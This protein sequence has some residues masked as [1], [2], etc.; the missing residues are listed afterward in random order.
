ME[1]VDIPEHHATSG[2]A[3]GDDDF[4]DLQAAFSDTPLGGSCHFDGLTSADWSVQ[5]ELRVGESSGVVTSADSPGIFVAGDSS[6]G[7]SGDLESEPDFVMVDWPNVSFG[8]DNT[9]ALDDP[10][11]EPTMTQSQFQQGFSRSLLT[12]C[13]AVSNIVMPWEQGVFRELFSDDPYGSVVPQMPLDNLVGPLQPGMEPQHVGEVVASATVFEQDGPVYMDVI[14]SKDDVDFPSR[15]ELLR[16]RALAKLLVV[17]EYSLE[18]SST[19]RHIASI[20]DGNPSASESFHILDAVV[21][22]RSPNTIMKRANSLLSFVH[23][24]SRSRAG[25]ANPFNETTLWAYLSELRDTNAAATKGEAVMSAMRFAH[26][27][28][29]FDTLEEAVISRRLIGISELMASGKRMLKQAKVLTVNQVKRLHQILRDE[30]LHMCDRAIC[31]YLLLALYGR[32]RH[33]DLQMI[34]SLECDFEGNGGYVVIQTLCHKTSRSAALKSTLLPIIIPARGVDGT[35]YASLA[36]SVLRMN[37]LLISSGP[38]NGP[39]LPAPVGIGE[40]LKR[41]MTSQESSRALR[42]LLEE[43][44]PLAGVDQEEISSHS[45]KATCLSWCAKYGLTPS[46]RSMLGRHASSV[47]ETFAIYS[48]DLAVAPAAELQRVV[49]D[50]CK[51]SF[52]PDG[53]RSSFFMQTPVPAGAADEVKAEVDTV[54]EAALH[55]P[56]VEIVISD[57]SSSDDGD[58]EIQSSEEEI[59]SDVVPKVKRFRAKIPARETWYSHRKSKILHKKDE[60]ASNFWGRTYLCCGKILSDAYE[61]CTESSAMNTLCKVCVRRSG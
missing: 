41:G 1:S 53:P 36:M 12:N 4:T 23:W 7:V 9:S 60:E 44:E 37:G 32:C 59:P 57:D 3:S 39:L 24:C 45:L 55:G 14:S 34:K 16:E 29:G 6:Q 48:R 33:S 5:S 61:L 40:F 18:S 49:D 46:T 11:D 8:A 26:Y 42:Q 28:L 56:S 27:I 19:G 21:G 58:D 15:M 13:T 38:I 54:E 10:V 30:T 2:G 22:L 35:A 50:I 31:A 47:T 25:D 20:G 17:I 43:C 52:S 51:G